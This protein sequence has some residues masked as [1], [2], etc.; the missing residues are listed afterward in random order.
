MLESLAEHRR[1]GEGKGL[2]TYASFLLKKGD[3]DV[4]TYLGAG[5]FHHGRLISRREP[6]VGDYLS[7]IETNIPAVS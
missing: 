2:Q 6:R 4:T 5:A 7:W 3:L 1:L